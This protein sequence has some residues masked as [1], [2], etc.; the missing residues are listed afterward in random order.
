MLRN[1]FQMV[2]NGLPEL[3]DPT[4]YRVWGLGF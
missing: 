4:A 2:F 1:I 3:A